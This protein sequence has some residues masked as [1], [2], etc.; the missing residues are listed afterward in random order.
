MPVIK[1]TG[2]AQ[3]SADTDSQSGCG[4]G[5]M[6]AV[7]C[8]EEEEEYEPEPPVPP[9]IDP[10]TPIGNIEMNLDVLL[11]HIL[12]EVHPDPADIEM[13]ETNTP[14]EQTMITEVI[15]PVVI[16]LINEDVVPNLPT[17]TLPGQ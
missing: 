13:P 1:P 6:M 14:E 7:G 10:E 15:E 9:K 3:T 16:Q 11:T 5:I 4:C 17:C 8:C 12:H 2:L